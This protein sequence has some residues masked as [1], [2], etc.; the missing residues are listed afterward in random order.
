MLFPNTVPAA[1]FE[2]VK[3]KAGVVVA[4]ATLVVKRGDRLPELK[5][6]T[7]PKV[8]LQPKPVVVDHVR[9]FA[10]VEPKAANV[11]NL[12]VNQCPGADVESW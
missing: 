10:Q 1:A 11:G 4:V 12:A 2:R 6:V 5:L 7:V 9:A 3:V 8:P